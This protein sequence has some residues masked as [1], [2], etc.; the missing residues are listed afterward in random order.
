MAS[1]PDKGAFPAE[2]RAVS[3]PARLKMGAVAAV[4]LVATPV[5]FLFNPSSVS[6]FPECPFHL[7]TGLYCPGC[8]SQRA[9]HALLHGRVLE[10]AGFNLLAVLAW[11]LLVYSAARF[12]ANHLFGLR[13][14]QRLFYR[15]WFSRMVLALVLTF[16]LIRNMPWSCF[17][18]MAP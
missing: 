13:W 7:L 11:P 18:W 14:S 6:F 9:F 3:L 8:G 12:V 4:L 2:R 16:W 17:S 15:P 10:A 1:T 5:Y